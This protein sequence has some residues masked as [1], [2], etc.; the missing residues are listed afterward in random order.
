M[1]FGRGWSDN[2]RE[3]PLTTEYELE[4]A[5]RWASGLNMF[6][7]HQYFGEDA[8]HKVADELACTTK[9]MRGLHTLFRQ[10]GIIDGKKCWTGRIRR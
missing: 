6:L 5:E 10:W 8:A 3:Y 9:N 1:I 4:H 7:A 2:K